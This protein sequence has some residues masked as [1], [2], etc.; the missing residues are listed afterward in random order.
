M[1]RI[2]LT[3]DDGIDAPG[4]RSLA[5]ALAV[6]GEPWVVAPEKPQSAVGRSMTFHKPLR[7][8]AVKKHWYAVNGTPADCVTLSLNHL[9]RDQPP[10]LVVSG[11]NHGWNLGDDVTNSGTVSGAL[12]G[13]LYNIPAIAISLGDPSGKKFAL[14]AEVAANIARQVVKHGL[15]RGTILNV[16]VPPCTKEELAGVQITTLSQRRYHN[17]VIEKI[18][19]RGRRYFW[20]AGERI[21]WARRSPSDHEAVSNN[22]VSITPLHL[23]LTDYSTFRKLKNWENELWSTSSPNAVPPRMKKPLRKS[24]KLQ[25]NE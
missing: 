20:I 16:N 25:S 10:A 14:A 21:S 4:I 22:L 9:L 12:E 13:M 2:L 5:K 7:L 19:P 6:L 18:D 23:D 8:Q 1:L 11:I 3:N 17:P 15:P 24:E